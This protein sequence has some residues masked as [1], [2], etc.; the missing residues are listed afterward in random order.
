[1]AYQ[2]SRMQI[3]RS[4]KLFG[5]LIMFFGLL[6]MISQPH[7]MNQVIKDQI[8]EGKTHD[9]ALGTPNSPLSAIFRQ[10]QVPIRSQRDSTNDTC[11]NYARYGTTSTS[12]SHKY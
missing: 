8:S 9:W 1:M 4:F 3:R 5:K 2:A 12:S 7:H 11:I 10:F 6:S